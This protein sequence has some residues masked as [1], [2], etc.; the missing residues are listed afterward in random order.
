MISRTTQTRTLEAMIILI[1]IVVLLVG[2]VFMYHLTPSVNIQMLMRQRIRMERPMQFEKAF[3]MNMLTL[4]V[5]K[6]I[7]PI[8]NVP[9]PH[10]Q[11]FFDQSSSPISKATTLLTLLIHQNRQHFLG[12][13]S[14]MIERIQRTIRL[15]QSLCQAIPTIIIS[16]TPR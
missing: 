2:M 12:R 16:R 9:H 6:V 10:L 4:M 8:K 1:W 14:C 5:K 15:K 13:S 11:L 7:R 3:M